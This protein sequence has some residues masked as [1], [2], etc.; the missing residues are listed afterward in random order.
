MEIRRKSFETMNDRTS[1][2][3]IGKNPSNKSLLKEKQRL[4]TCIPH[5]HM[6]DTQGKKVNFK[7]AALTSGLNSIFHGNKERRVWADQLSEG[8]RETHQETTARLVLQ[9]TWV[10]LPLIRVS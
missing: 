6:G 8:N 4:A 3:S 9:I 1:K 5:V 7:E 2:S 10:P